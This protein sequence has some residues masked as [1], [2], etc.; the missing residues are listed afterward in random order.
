MWL[1][2]LQLSIAFLWLGN[3]S[4]KL[5]GWMFWS[6]N[7]TLFKYGIGGENFGICIFKES[8]KVFLCVILTWL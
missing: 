4:E 2:L 7:L 3:V 6:L 5:I 8:I 1:L